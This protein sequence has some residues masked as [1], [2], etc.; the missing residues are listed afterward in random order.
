[1]REKNSTNW[2]NTKNKLKNIKQILIMKTINRSMLA[3]GLLSF[4]FQSCT[5]NDYIKISD[6]DYAITTAYQNADAVNGAKLFSNFQHVDAG[7]AW[8]TPAD[9][10]AN[11]ALA[12]FIGWPNP[13][14]AADPTLTAV[15]IKAIGTYTAQTGVTT[16][17]P[18]PQ[19]NRNFYSCAGCHPVDGMARDASGISKK[20]AKTQP[21]IAVNQLLATKTWDPKKLFDAIKGVG[22][23]AIDATKTADGLDLTKGGQTHPDFSRILT[24]EKIWDL[25]KWLKEGMFNEND[26]FVNQLTTFIA[27]YPPPQR[28]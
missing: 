22:G 17:T 25:V 8:V 27:K 20:V 5:N 26:D 18:A 3:I 4:V 9:V 6:A 15:E 16:P 14:F 7:W 23:R 19:A 10:T 28:D 2:T 12:D 21:D 1:M 24:D 13:K 11:A